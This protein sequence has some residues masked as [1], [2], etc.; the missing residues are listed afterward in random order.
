MD[1]DEPQSMQKS[2]ATA[3]SQC[4]AP[5]GMALWGHLACRAKR[6]S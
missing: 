3:R 6:I 2:I 4:G 5:A 1:W